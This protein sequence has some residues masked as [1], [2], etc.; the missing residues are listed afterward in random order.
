MKKVLLIIAMWTAFFVY[1]CDKDEPQGYG[2]DQGCNCGIICE[3]GIDSAN[4]CY[5]FIVENDCSGASKTF[6]VDQL[7]WSAY[8]VGERIC[9][10]EQS[11]W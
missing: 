6:C 2:E 7:V 11:P 8:S 10:N 4:Q 3:D 1:A 9:I 5:W